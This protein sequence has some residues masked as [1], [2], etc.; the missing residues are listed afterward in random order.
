MKN[1]RAAFKA[2]FIVFNS[3][4]YAVI[5]TKGGY[6]RFAGDITVHNFSR[7][8]N[9]QINLSVGQHNALEEAKEILN[10]QII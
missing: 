10:N 8:C 5:S 3:D 4:E 1:I 7:I 9:E 2:F 6:Y